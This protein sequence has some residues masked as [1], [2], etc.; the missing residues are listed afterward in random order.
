MPWGKG[1]QECRRREHR[2]SID[3]VG[4][5]FRG[6]GSRSVVSISD[7][8][9]EGCQLSGGEFELKEGIRL[10]IPDRGEMGARVRWASKGKSGALFTNDEKLAASVPAHD[11]NAITRMAS[12]NYGTG[13]VFGRKGLK[14]A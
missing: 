7:I 2:R 1:E 11:R 12:L 10:V 3:L 9:F 14:A 5:A 6:D 8:S 4:L 13:R